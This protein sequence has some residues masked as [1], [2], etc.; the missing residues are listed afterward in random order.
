MTVRE[1]KAMLSQLNDE[2]EIFVGH[3]DDMSCTQYQIKKL[4]IDYQAG[5]FSPV[6]VLDAE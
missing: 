3:E 2:T 6:L 5:C 1:L 4:I